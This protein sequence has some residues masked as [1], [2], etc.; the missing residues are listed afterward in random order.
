VSGV[1]RIRSPGTAPLSLASRRCRRREALS[2]VV[3]TGLKRSPPTF[4]NCPLGRGSEG[5][6]YALMHSGCFRG[7]SDKQRA[8]CRCAAVGR[9]LDLVVVRPAAAAIV[10]RMAA[11]LYGDS[12]PDRRWINGCRK[13]QRGLV[14]ER[15]SLLRHIQ[16]LA[17]ASRRARTRRSRL[18][19]MD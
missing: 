17:L 12:S 9:D 5:V 14:D 6:G 16:K 2:E 11:E 7:W 4:G 18:L 19:T 13:K 8:E 10:L 15:A 1:S 3:L